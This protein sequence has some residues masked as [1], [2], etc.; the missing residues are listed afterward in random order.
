MFC[1]VP[2]NSDGDLIILSNAYIKYKSTDT[3]K[4][5]IEF[6]EDGLILE[7]TGDGIMVTIKLI[8]KERA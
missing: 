4:E 2:E 8:A 3:L 7:K 6:K 1:S 5:V